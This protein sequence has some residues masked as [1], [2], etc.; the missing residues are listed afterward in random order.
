M[1]FLHSLQLN[2]HTS[3][4]TQTTGTSGPSGMMD[5]RNLAVMGGGGKSIGPFETAVSTSMHNLCDSQ[6]T[7]KY[8]DA[9]KH[10]LECESCVSGVE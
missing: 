7:L 4:D 10:D 3:Y 5:R 2:F 1:T 9:G 6:C 8:V